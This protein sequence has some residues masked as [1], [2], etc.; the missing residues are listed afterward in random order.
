MADRANLLD[1]RPGDELGLTSPLP[2]FFDKLAEQR[3]RAVQRHGG[4]TTGIGGEIPFLARHIRDQLLSG[5]RAMGR[6]ARG[7]LDPTSR[8]GVGEALNIAMGTMGASVPFAPKGS[9]GVFGGKLAA[10]ADKRKLLDAMQL[11]LNGVPREHIWNETGW[12]KG[13]DGE[14]RFEIPDTGA[15]VIPGMAGEVGRLEKVLEHPELYKAY[16]QLRDA[17]VDITAG[18]G[19]EYS[20]WKGRPEIQLGEDA[21]HNPELALH[22][23]QHAIQDIEGFAKGGV[24]K[25]TPTLEQAK[26]AFKNYKNLAGEVEARTVEHRYGVDQLQQVPELAARLIDKSPIYSRPPWTSHDVPEGKQFVTQTPVWA[27][28]EEYIAADGKRYAIHPQSGR[29]HELVPVE[30]NP[31][32]NQPPAASASVE[33]PGLP[34]EGG[35]S[36]FITAYHGSPHSFDRFDLSKLGTGE[37]SQAYGHGL[38]FAEN[39]GVANSYA[40]STSHRDFIRKVQELYD[41]YEDPHEAAAIVNESSD[42]TPSQRELVNSLREDDFLGF[43]YPHQA[44]TAAIKEPQ[45]FDMSD[46]TKEALKNLGARYKVKINA[47]SEHFLDWDK[48]LSEQSPKVQEAIKP[49]LQNK[50]RW[51]TAL[52]KALGP[53]DVDMSQKGSRAY[54][55]LRSSLSHLNPLDNPSDPL[56]GRPYATEPQVSQALREAG[57]PGIKYL[58]AGSRSQAAENKTRNFVV[59]DDKLVDILKKYGIAGMGAFPAMNA[60]H[61]QEKE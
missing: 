9:L 37:G 57:I 56:S 17:T 34:T 30:H 54:H 39:E 8:E 42:F 15:K 13:T 45:N 60:Y 43:D 24:P 28:P 52:D 38:Y 40:K 61:Y 2:D 4:P 27:T 7:E 20:G 47:N 3:R 23:T 5:P 49:L 46:R 51:K 12:F 33:A 59:F 36:D 32:E 31:F 53:E 58:D 29:I 25:A 41:E 48:P 14:W 6:V 1:K 21:M 10:T 11:E 50:P 18:R 44:V 55:S 16:P 22:E 26:A 19:G 35:L